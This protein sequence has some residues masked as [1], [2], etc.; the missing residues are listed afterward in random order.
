MREDVETAIRTTG[1]KTIRV[2]PPARWV[3]VD[4]ADLW[5][6]RELLYFFIW[7]HLKLRYKQT[8]LGAAWAVLQPLLTMLTF[9]VI[10]G[11]LAKLPSDGLPY[12]VFYYTGLLPWLYFANALTAATNSMV[13]HQRM[14]TKVYFP[15][16]LLPAA[17]VLAGLV[18]FAAAFGVLLLLMLWYGIAPTATVWLA[19]LFLL[20]AVLTALGVGL[21]L[22][23]LYARFRD[24]R[25]A[26]QFM[27]MLWMFVSPVLYPSTMIPERFRWLYG[28]NPIAGV[29]EGFRWTVTGTA[30]PDASLLITSTLVAA[31]TV[32]GGLLYFQHVEATIADVV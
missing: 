32:V 12:P 6:H 31:G 16:L 22:A 20:L 26:L 17:A 28:L 11:H 19:P 15:R 2:A 29:L 24:V 30:Q 10:F 9:T 21:A 25:Y 8:A 18:D 4:L 1:R 5:V 14:I 7:R 3:E 23:A 13:D 27:V